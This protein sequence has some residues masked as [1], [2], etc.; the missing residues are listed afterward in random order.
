[1][2]AAIYTRVS[3]DKRDKASVQQQEDE[4]RLAAAALGWT[5]VEVFSDNDISASRHAR[6]EREHHTAL[7]AAIQAGTV[8]VVILWESSRGDRKL[9]TWSA[10][11]DLCR[12]RGVK[13]HVVDHRRTYDLTVPRDWKTL[14]DEGVNNAYA[15]EETR[16]RILRDV[17]AN[18]VAGRPHG[19]LAFGYT[20]RYDDRGNF[21]E[22]VEH[23][24]QA[25]I[26][27]ECGR[28]VEAGESLYGIAQDLN[29]REVPAPRG[30]KWLPL[31][32][33]RVVTNPRYVGQR[34]HRGVV[35]GD[36]VWPAI[37]EENVYAECV[38]RMS[39]PRRHST[40]DLSLKHLLSGIM[41]APC[42]GR[43]RVL[44]NRGYWSYICHQDY[45]VSVRTTKV[46]EFVTD[47]VIERLEQP[48]VM[49]G[50]AAR[51]DQAVAGAS[52]QADELQRR[53]DGFVDAAARGELTPAALARIEQ[54]LLPEIEDAKR[55]AQVAPLPKLIRDVA[56]PGAR[57]R[58]GRLTIGQ[59]REVIDKVAEIRVAA[60]RK[61]V[62]F[63]FH[64][65]APS[66]WRG[67]EQTWGDHWAAL[68][69]S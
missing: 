36:A 5:V 11:L 30:G 12:D 40:R 59:R 65:L 64:R 22:Q 28:R 31:Q 24:E 39:D 50:L 27:R 42:G 6:K 56:G 67:D 51:S 7:L 43:T 66:R 61:G 35:V 37:L 23:P 18:A 60:S 32:I 17:R 15:S 58:W 57:E 38:R 69:P 53:L 54:R 29:R 14:A 2:R 46:E 63:S 52:G 19:K 13:I 16:E 8:D 26:V 3:Q 4:A 48:D 45:C 33:K 49:R 25:E 21:V 44:K 10:L 34:V 55:L 9:T 47:Q 1:M 41:V 20:R 68:D 62:R